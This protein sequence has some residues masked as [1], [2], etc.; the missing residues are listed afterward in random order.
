MS[1]TAVRFIA[2]PILI[3]VVF[4]GYGNGLEFTSTLLDATA[5]RQYYESLGLPLS[6]VRSL[7]LLSF[8]IPHFLLVALLAFAFSHIAARIYGPQALTVAILSVLPVLYLRAGELFQPVSY[9]NRYSSIA[10]LT[11]SAFEI[12]SFVLLLCLGT[13]LVSKRREKQQAPQA[14]PKTL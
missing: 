5:I 3:T 6:A 9:L 4:L 14:P 12:G 2:L 10:S 7:V 11:L 13:W 1:N 8:F